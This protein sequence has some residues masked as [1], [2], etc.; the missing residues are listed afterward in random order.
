VAK[1]PALNVAGLIAIDEARSWGTCAARPALYQ[2][3]GE[4][5]NAATSTQWIRVP[6][7]L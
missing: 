7:I 6:P 2:V 4:I 1:T 3:N 5:T